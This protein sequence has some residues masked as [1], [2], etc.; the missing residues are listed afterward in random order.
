LWFRRLYRTNKLIR[1]ALLRRAIGDE[2]KPRMFRR[3]LLRFIRAVRPSTRASIKCR[4]TGKRSSAGSRIR[5]KELGTARG[6]PMEFVQ[7]LP[8]DAAPAQPF[9]MSGDGWVMVGFS[10]SDVFGGKLHAVP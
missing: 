7:R 9:A 4:V 2:I 8:G 1:I 10:G 6:G 3:A 5:F